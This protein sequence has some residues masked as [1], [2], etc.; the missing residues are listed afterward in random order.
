MEDILLNPDGSLWVKRMTVGLSRAGEVSSSPA[1][2]ARST[3]AARRGAVLNHERPILETKLP[4][5]GNRFEA[6]APARPG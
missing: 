6:I 1:S 3:I 5:D 2:S 4:L